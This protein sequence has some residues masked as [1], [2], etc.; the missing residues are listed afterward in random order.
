MD[1]DHVK[2]SR[3]EPTTP[4]NRLWNAL[5]AKQL[6]GFKFRQQ[7]KSGACGPTSFVRRWEW[8]WRWTG[9]PT[10]RKRTPPAMHT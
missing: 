1:R 10:M 5:R 7:H 8:R 2:A 9:I 6:G 3:A 4:E